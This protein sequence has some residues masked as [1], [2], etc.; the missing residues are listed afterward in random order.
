MSKESRITISVPENIKIQWQEAAE[1]R[2][3]TLSAF[4]RHCMSVY[5]TAF[6]KK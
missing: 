4:I 3:M 5:M 6:K 2:G 1:E